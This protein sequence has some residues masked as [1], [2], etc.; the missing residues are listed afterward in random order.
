MVL[1]ESSCTA[2]TLSSI[3]LMRSDTF[4]T[5]S[6]G[7]DIATSQISGAGGSPL[8]GT[9]VV[10]RTTHPAWVRD[11]LSV[12]QGSGMAEGASRGCRR[13][14]SLRLGCEAFET[15]QD[16][17]VALSVVGV[18]DFCQGERVEDLDEPTVG[19]T[20]LMHH[21]LKGTKS[22]ELRCLA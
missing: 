21:P 10:T 7:S 1:A 2:S 18:D 20:A 11:A 17:G 6:L 8:S 15:S 12:M 14:P 22:A 5:A 19:E 13:F 16:R 9:G 4:L 3:A